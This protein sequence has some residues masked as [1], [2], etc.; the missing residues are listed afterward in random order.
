MPGQRESRVAGYV[1]PFCCADADMAKQG[2]G[3]VDIVWVFD[4]K[5][6]GRDVPEQVSVDGMPESSPGMARQGFLQAS[7]GEWG[8]SLS[9]P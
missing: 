9:D 2:D 7:R 8:S 1:V 4:G 5:G 3:I 6:R